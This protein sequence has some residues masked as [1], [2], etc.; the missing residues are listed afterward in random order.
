MTSLPLEGIRIVDLCTVLMG[1]LCTQILADH[2]AEVIKIEPVSGDTTRWIGP[3]TTPGMGP[4]FLNLNRGKK[5]VAMDLRDERCQTALRSLVAKA[6]VVVHNLRPKVA[7]RRGLDFET[8]RKINPKLVF[9]NLYGYGKD[10]PYRDRPAYDD[11][12]QGACGLP[13]LQSVAGSTNPRYVPVNLADRMVGLMATA[14]IPMA[15]IAVM[16]TGK[17]QQVEL[18]MFEVLASQVLSDHLY[19]HSFDPKKGTPGY[20]RLLSRD[21]K[22]FQ[23]GD[24]YICV[25]IYNDKHWRAFLPAIGRED[26]LEDSRMKN[27]NSRMEHID[28][29]SSFISEILATRTS[30]EWSKFFDDLDIPVAPMNSLDSLLADPQ[31]IA[32]K[33]VVEQQHP[34]EGKIRA[35]SNPLIWGDDSAT[36]GFAPKLGQDTLEVLLEV[37]FSRDDVECMAREKVVA[38]YDQ[39]DDETV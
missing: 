1:P 31:T 34:T 24:G 22:P 28:F 38:L 14:A 11:L 39:F 8:L 20:P 37:G 35:V 13:Y 27:I 15:L 10:G 26:L 7:A 5:A 17:A 30:A 33:L 21:R 12:I 32:S 2:G 18:P 19:G 23:T 25:A 3:S 6:D 9:C 36:V 29:V 16:K 4:M